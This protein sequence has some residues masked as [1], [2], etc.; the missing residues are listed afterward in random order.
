MDGF[1]KHIKKALDRRRID[2]S[3]GSWER[4]AGQLSVPRRDK[5]GGWKAY[6]LAACFA[7]ILLLAIGTLSKGE[8]GAGDNPLVEREGPKENGPGPTDGTKV[9]PQV[10]GKSDL[11]LPN[12]G[13]GPHGVADTKAPPLESKALEQEFSVPKHV[14]ASRDTLAHRDLENG[15]QDLILQKAREVVAQVEHWE[16]QQQEV[17]QGEVDSLLRAAQGQILREKFMQNSGSVDALVLL[18]EVEGELDTSFR[19]QLFDALKAGYFK[20]RT[21]VADRNN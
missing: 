9:D 11:A 20:L 3:P 16:R 12:P 8:K 4:L 17:S 6:A 15:P 10:Q 21:A 2:P 19:D 5:R 7:G 1:E 18:A 13:P 14:L